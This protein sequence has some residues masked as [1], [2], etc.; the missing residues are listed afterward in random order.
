MLKQCLYNGHKM[1]KCAVWVQMPGE[2]HIGSRLNIPQIRCEWQ[3]LANHGSI[4][5]MTLS[6]M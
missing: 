5:K 2:D 4:D 3:A 1:W 6:A